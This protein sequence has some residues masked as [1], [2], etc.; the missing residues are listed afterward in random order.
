MAG[1]GSTDFETWRADIRAGNLRTGEEARA[2][3]AAFLTRWRE[4]GGYEGACRRAARAPS[5][6]RWHP[7]LHPI[8]AASGHMP[9]PGHRHCGEIG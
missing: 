9:F 8:Q 1:C 3:S 2:D 5:N 7:E 4:Q 6:D